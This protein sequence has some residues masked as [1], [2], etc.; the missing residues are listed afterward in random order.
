MKLTKEEESQLLDKITSIPLY[1][2][3]RWDNSVEY[4]TYI[5]I[6]NTI[7]VSIGKKRKKDSGYKLHLSNYD[8]TNILTINLSSLSKKRL[9]DLFSLIAEYEEEEEIKQNRI[10]YKKF[11]DGI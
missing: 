8:G 7:Q 11:F 9:F 5:F 4:T 3:R 2:W 10:Q 6:K 1:E